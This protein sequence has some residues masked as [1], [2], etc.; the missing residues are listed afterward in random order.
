MRRQSLATFEEGNQMSKIM[1]QMYAE[2]RAAREAKEDPDDHRTRAAPTAASFMLRWWSLPVPNPVESA[3]TTIEWWL[4]K[5]AATGGRLRRRDALVDPLPARANGYGMPVFD[6]RFPLGT[7]LN[8]VAKLPLRTILGRPN[9]FIDSRG[10]ERYVEPTRE[11]LI[12]GPASR[13]P[14]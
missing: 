12:R 1:R 5:I 6:P 7:P 10:V 2:A 14:S 4:N 3:R 8:R 9:W 11:T 13:L